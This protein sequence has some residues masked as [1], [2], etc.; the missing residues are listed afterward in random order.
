[1]LGKTPKSTKPTARS[2]PELSGSSSSIRNLVSYFQKARI[3]EITPR[4]IELF[5]K[6][7]LSSG[8]RP[9]TVNR[10][11]AVCRRMLKLAF[12]QRLITENPFIQLLEERRGRRLP[13]IL[14]WVEQEKLLAVA[15]PRIRLEVV[16]GPETGVRT[17]EMFGLRW[18]DVDFEN[19]VIHIRKSK[20]VSGIRSAPISGFCK[21]ELIRWRDLL[22]PQFSEWVFPQFS[23]TRHRLK[24]GRK[25]W[26][27]ALKKAGI[28]Y[29]RRY[30]LRHCFASRLSAAGASPITIAG[31]LGHS[32]TGIVMTYAKANHRCTQVKSG[33]EASK[34]VA[35][36]TV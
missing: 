21:V 34:K 17:R 18:S 30:D 2:Y 32:S 26:A 13:H 5:K 22:G 14:T 29:F 36:M 24:G 4:D 19:E 27:S 8:A 31:L 6:Q 28:S 23:G 7:R 35:K 12:Q 11:L 9:A 3:S 1:M 10:E 33:Q 16:M 15:P 20:T 25:A